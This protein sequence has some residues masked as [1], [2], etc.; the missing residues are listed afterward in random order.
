[1]SYLT[2]LAPSSPEPHR[3][4]HRESLRSAFSRWILAN[5]GADHHAT[6]GAQRS[7]Q[8]AQRFRDAFANSRREAPADK[9]LV[10]I[11]GGGFAGLFA[12]LLLRSLGVECELF[13]SSERVGGRIRT[14]YSTDY[15]AKKRD[16]AGLYGEL[17]GMRVPQFPADMLPVQALALA[18]NAVLDR[19]GL[20]A[21]KVYW[22]KFYY[23]S[24]EQRLR[25]NDMPSFTTAEQSEIESFNFGRA[26][27]G[28]VPDVWTTPA[29][30]A[31]GKRYL[32]I[33]VVLEQ[34]NAPFLAAFNRS[35][36]EGFELLMQFDQ[37]SMWDYLTTQFRL[38][39]LGAYYDPAMGGKS[40]LLPWSVA[41]FL[42]T[43]NVG[44]GMY[45]VSFV[46]MV[47]AVY[48]WGGSKD[49][50]RPDD[51][52]VYML[53]VD[54]GMQRFPDACHRVL[55][56]AD[57]VS[58]Q[59]G[60]TAQ[61][62]V[63]MLPA[64]PGGAYSYDPPNL[65]P[66]AQPRP[67]TTT[68]A[69]AASAAPTGVDRNAGDRRRVHLR[70]KVV[71]LRHDRKL[72]DGHGGMRVT[73]EDHGS[74][75]EPRRFEREYPYVIA[76]LPT[77]A[78][79]N[80]NERLNLIEDL[81]F[82]KA[83][84]LR[85][86]DY[87][88]AFK[89]FLTFK[90]QFWQELGRRQEG[91]YGAAATD[92]PNR[93]IIYPSYGYDAEG[94]VLQVYCWAMDARKLGALGDR[95]RVDECLKGIQYLYP[96]VDVYAHFAGY[97]DGKTT[98]TWFWDEHA[99]GGAF[100]LFNPGQFKY[101]YPSLLTPEFD[102]CLNLAGESG[103]VHHGWIVGAMDSAYNAVL[104]ILEQAGARE[105]IAQLKAT[106]GSFSTPDV[107]GDPA[108]ANRLEYAHRYNQVDRSAAAAMPGAT[109]IYGKSSYV[110]E[111][112][113]P[114][115]IK[116]YSRVPQSMKQTQQDKQVLAMLNAQWNDNVAQRE[117]L[118]PKPVRRDDAA[119]MLEDIYYGNNFQTIPSPTAWLKDDDEFARQQLAGF[120]PNLLTKIDDAGLKRLLTEAGI[121]DVSQARGLA[122]VK[123]VADYRR[124]LSACNVIPQGYYL[125]KP[126]VLFSVSPQNEL[127][128]V[129][130]QLETGGELFTPG[131][132]NAANAWLL[133]KMLTNCA[134]QTLH[135]VGFH[136]LLTHQ[137]CALVS[138]ALLS[139]E[140]FNPA[141]P[142]RSPEP[143][144]EH[145]VFRLLRPHVVK[146]V[147]FQQTIY[148]SGYDPYA[149]SFPAT[150]E[151]NGAPGVYN[152]GFVYDLIFS[153]GRIGNYQL[154]DR[155]YNDPSFQVLDL[156]LPVDV[157]RRGVAS[158]PFSYPY[159]HDA[160][161]WYRAISRFVASFV[162]AQYPGGDPAI[163][164][165]VQ[166]QRFFDK[167][168]PAFNHVDENRRADR[169]PAE[170]KTTARLKQVL[171]FFVWQF[172]VQHTVV[173]DGAY[174]QA[175][176][177]PNASTLMYAPPT[178]KPSAQWTP[179]DVLACLPSQTATYPTLGGMTFMDVQINASVTGQGPYPE[180]VFGRGLLEPAIDVLQDT[181]GFTNPA[182][183]RAVDAF[184][185][186]AR[187]VA[188]AIRSRQAKDS[189]RYLA[190]HPSA[191]A[192]PE[193][194]LFPRLAP[195]EVMNTI[196]T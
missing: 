165:D 4:A 116:D 30:D 191:Q 124:Y 188:E 159:V 22:R 152:I 20:S 82:A 175:A 66:D 1:M 80:G 145:P 89:A 134:G 36:A 131:M 179:A 120:M 88:P 40:D 72:F 64:T 153:C 48:D 96:D 6:L 181:Y 19:N 189:A 137:L 140:V 85:E 183:R 46:E 33:N 13:E 146:A 121:T 79:L 42:E 15:D 110:F 111:G 115:F 195:V 35:F 100:A 26:Q 49:P 28:D 10:G 125:P 29:T 41:S 169:F 53:T 105:K 185:Q 174:N 108:T 31:S 133:A 144:Q 126:I 93:Q 166:L 142:P 196:Q 155:I 97:A 157:E 151:V 192:V 148:N 187:S 143:F 18:V 52:G 172:S 70:H 158:T 122:Q 68:R 44:S 180:T 39:D 73:V 16:Q 59:D 154:Q 112:Q 163:A 3:S 178:A 147:E 141:T 103:S 63:G 193:T 71:A 25:Y 57:S 76:T 65:T 37:Y 190:L 149:K 54:Q 130:I 87:M 12:G 67:P 129:A 77:G 177:V 104:N 161:H 55:D 128:P 84:A 176:F 132:P 2:F 23:N 94:G 168:I 75:A 45:A 51:D 109:S 38:G 156:A 194:V 7:R 173:N 86:C 27:G 56:L 135:D 138:I 127:L 184:Y 21:D 167:L 139:E 182:L 113:V 106:W 47:I 171:T 119:Q 101:L 136:Q 74:G 160:S 98:K 118:P 11:I 92:R 62:Q 107:E 8:D 34:V 24:P 99:G 170:V 9:P 117:K 5:Y 162:D 102:G 150:R 32:P 78:Y 69:A 50:Y 90:R 186:D 114:A 43:T 123:Y 60:A 95:E 14:W 83:Q 58:Q 91:G 61:I 81:S 17:G 164:A